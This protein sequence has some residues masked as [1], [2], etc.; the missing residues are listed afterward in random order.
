MN[1]YRDFCISGLVF[2]KNFENS[3]FDLVFT[4]TYTKAD[5]KILN[6]RSPDRSV[7]RN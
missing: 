3:Q 7:V 6:P 5:K 2:D 1:A 4:S